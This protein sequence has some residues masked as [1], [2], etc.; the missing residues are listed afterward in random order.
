MPWAIQDSLISTYGPT[1][2][3]QYIEHPIMA[4]E[5][6]KLILGYHSVVST[7]STQQWVPYLWRNGLIHTIGFCIRGQINLPSPYKPLT[8]H[9]QLELLPLID[10]LFWFPTLALYALQQPFKDQK[11]N[12]TDEQICLRVILLFYSLTP[13]IPLITNHYNNVPWFFDWTY[14]KG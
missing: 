5:G 1:P 8:T 13:Q 12:R 10:S 3:D 11:W 6:K 2:C 14:F 9:Y 7:S 4:Y